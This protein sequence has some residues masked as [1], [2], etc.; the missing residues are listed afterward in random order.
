MMALEPLDTKWP[1]G[2]SARLGSA[3]AEECF[4]TS[5]YPYGGDDLVRSGSC[6]CSRTPL[7]SLR[8]EI[9]R[10][11]HPSEKVSTQPAPS[12]FTRHPHFRQVNRTEL[13]H[14]LTGLEAVLDG[15][16]LPLPPLTAP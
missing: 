2:N 5:V 11:R 8:N 7:P 4:A 1:R 10:D 9:S 15:E 13:E 12:M 14:L 6:V 3:Q 16:R